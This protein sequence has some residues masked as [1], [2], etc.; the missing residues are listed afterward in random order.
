[1]SIKKSQQ[2]RFYKHF[3]GLENCS[4]KPD[5]IVL[6]HLDNNQTLPLKEAQKELIP[7]IAISDTNTNPENV[8]VS[9]PGND[10]NLKALF[11]YTQLLIGSAIKGTKN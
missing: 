6:F 7:T 11:L 8:T 5:L 9:I 2:R 1:L 3:K 10:D 4:K